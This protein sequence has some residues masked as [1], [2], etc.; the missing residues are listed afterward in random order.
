MSGVFSI[1]F[2]IHGFAE[3]GRKD[4]NMVILLLIDSESRNLANELVD[5]EEAGNFNQAVMVLIL[6]RILSHH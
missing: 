3:E 6:G 1:I 4:I 2:D 5:P